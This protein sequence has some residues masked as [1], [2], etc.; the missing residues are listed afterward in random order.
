MASVTL[1]WN[2]DPATDNVTGYQIWGANGTSVAFGS[3]TKLATVSATS[4]TDTGLPNNQTRTYYILAVNAAGSSSPEGPINITTAAASSTYVQNLG[5]APSIQAGT[6]AARPSPGNAGAI[7][8]ET[9]T[10][11]I[12]RDTGAAWAMIGG[13]GGSPAAASFTF[14]GGNAATG[15]RGFVLNCGSSAAVSE[16]DFWVEG[17]SA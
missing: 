3:C 13:G 1:T 15:G 9:D 14:D 12:F 17:G 8:I 5:S 2:A 7:Y 16:I 11:S 10:F 6:H 4:W